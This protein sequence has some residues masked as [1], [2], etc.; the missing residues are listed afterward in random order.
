[1]TLPLKQSPL[2]FFSRLFSLL[3]ELKIL[4]SEIMIL[5]FEIKTYKD[6]NLLQADFV[7][8]KRFFNI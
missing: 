8:F 7:H 5:V 3:F 4:V 2:C 6:A 1:M